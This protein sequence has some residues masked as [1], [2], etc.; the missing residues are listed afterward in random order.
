MENKRRKKKEKEKGEEKKK[1]KEKEEKRKR[2]RKKKKKKKRSSPN[3]RKATKSFPAIIPTH[4]PQPSRG[5]FSEFAED[6]QK[7]VGFLQRLAYESII[8]D[9]GLKEYPELQRYLAAP[10]IA[11]TDDPLEW[12]AANEFLLPNLAIIARDQLSMLASTVPSEEAFSAAG[13]TITSKRK[14]KKRERCDSNSK[15]KKKTGTSA[16][17]IPQY[18]LSPSFGSSNT[19]HLPEKWEI[20]F[21][22]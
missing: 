12:W 22:N 20:V 7:P 2:K 8:K 21:S 18:N 6:P 1:E 10:T 11:M 14:K 5:I 15:K 3:R 13:N 9:K 17:R 19:S 16:P 4:R